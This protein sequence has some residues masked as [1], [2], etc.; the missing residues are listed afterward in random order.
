MQPKT[1]KLF[2][3]Y[4]SGV[5]VSNGVPAVKNEAV[6]YTPTRQQMLFSALGE[7]AEFLKNIQHIP[8]DSQ[9]GEKIGLGV[10][11]PIA[12]RTD[13]NSSERE[14]KYVGNLKG[15]KYHCKQT[16]FDTH[17]SYQ[18]MDSWAHAG[19]FS[20]TYINQVVKQIAR[21]VLMIGWNGKSAADETDIEANP[22]LQDVNVGWLEKVVQNEPDRYMGYDSEG[23]A[24]EQTWNLGEGG[25]YNN[26]DSLVFDMTVNLLD[27]WHQGSDDLVVIVGREIWVEHGLTLLYHSTLPTERNALS[28]WFASQTV[29]GMPCVM[30][31]FFPKR[32]VVVTSY[33]NLSVYHQ[34]NTLRRTIMDNPKRDRVEEYFSENQAY[35]VEDYGKFAGV[36]DGALLLPD[37]EGGFT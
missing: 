37:G 29:A 11:R 15:D 16:N 27:E 21:D 4:S 35:V 10:N 31:P 25:D 30:P 18:L 23:V 36:R 20:K 7:N 17:I 33:S 14:T 26:L 9:L 13:T 24:T 1:R 5:A 28:T 12:G 2:N 19:D 32:G 8:V 3:S 6:Q 34:L 22:L